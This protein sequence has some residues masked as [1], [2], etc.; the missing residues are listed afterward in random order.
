MAR[1]D[2]LTPE[3]LPQQEQPQEPVQEE[4]QEAAFAMTEEEVRRAMEFFR[5]EQNLVA[6]GLA[7]LVAA[8]T[9]AAIWAGIT[10]ATDYQIGWMAVGIGFLV[11]IAVRTVGK[12]VDQVFGITGAV[13]ALIGCALGNVFTVAYFIAMQTGAPLAEVLTQLDVDLL[14]EMLISTFQVTDLL[15][16]G[17]AVYFGYRYAFRE[18]TMDD[19]NRALG[20]A[21]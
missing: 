2:D 6:G 15:F 19:F 13:M 5:Q 8:V 18:L 9:G 21:L 16:Y 14:L 17:M 10:V 20:R 3:N 12:G 7:G 1:K 11:G 4:T